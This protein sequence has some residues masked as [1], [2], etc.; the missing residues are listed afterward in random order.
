V[1]FANLINF[2]KAVKNAHDADH[3]C[4]YSDTTDNLSS[5][6]KA[7]EKVESEP[8]VAAPTDNTEQIVFQAAPPPSAE[9]DEKLKAQPEHPKDEL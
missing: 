6:D 3:V 4:V 8:V 7:T 1:S 9:P 2:N 5:K